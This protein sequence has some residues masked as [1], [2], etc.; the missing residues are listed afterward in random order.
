MRAYPDGFWETVGARWERLASGD[1]AAVEMAVFLVVADPWFFRSGYTKV[2]LLRR[3][4]RLPLNKRMQAR[5]RAV[6]LAAVDS[7][8][9]RE[10]RRYCLLA[11][12]VRDSE[13]TATLTRRLH[14][15]DAGVRRRAEWMLAAVE[16]RPVRAEVLAAQA[17]W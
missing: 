2:E 12:N 4:V 7:R 6:C 16:R 5:L 14:S 17:A 3:L 15:E 11:R 10:F 1:S 9:R 13:F 8:D